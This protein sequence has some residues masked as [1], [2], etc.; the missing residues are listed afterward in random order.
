MRHQHRELDGVAAQRRA[1]SQS[2]RV[3]PRRLQ[4]AQRQ[5]GLQGGHGGAQTG[6]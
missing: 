4:G 5:P 2:L 3:H 1:Q 6:K